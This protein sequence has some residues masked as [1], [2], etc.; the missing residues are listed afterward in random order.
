M[1]PITINKALMETEKLLKM[2][3]LDYIIIEPTAE[4][5]EVVPRFKILDKEDAE[6]LGDED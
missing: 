1:N 6:A 2:P 3:N 5:L 4:G